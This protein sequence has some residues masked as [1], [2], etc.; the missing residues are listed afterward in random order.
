MCYVV[1]SVEHLGRVFQIKHRRKGRAGIRE[2]FAWQDQPVDQ[3]MIARTYP[4]RQHLDGAVGARQGDAELEHRHDLEAREPDAAEH[5]PST[6]PPPSSAPVLRRDSTM[7]GCRTNSPTSPPETMAGSWT[8]SC[9]F[10]DRH[11]HRPCPLLDATWPASHHPCCHHQPR[12]CCRSRR[13][14]TPVRRR[15]RRRWRGGEPAW[16]FAAPF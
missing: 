16:G 2:V 3:T 12:R 1:Y 10:T 4:A 8:L 7:S 14:A 13:F 15:T 6:P 5:G 9:R 11:A